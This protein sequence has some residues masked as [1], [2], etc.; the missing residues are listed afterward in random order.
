MERLLYEPQMFNYMPESGTEKYIVGTYYVEDWVEGGADFLD[1]LSGVKRMI[2]EGSTG[3]WQEVKEE[4]PEVRE[5]LAGKLLGYYEV[6][7]PEGIKRAIVQIGFPIDAWEGNVPMMLLSFAGNCFAYS[8]NLRLLDVVIPHE[9]AR[10]F[11]GPKFGIQG[12]RS[13]LNVYGRPLSLHIIKPKMGMTPEQTAA[14]VYE[15]ALGGVDMVKDDEMTS[16]VFNSKF[17]DR[18]AAVMDA[19]KR[20]EKKTGKKVIYFISVTDEIDVL[21]EKARRAV[22]HGANGL[23]LTY[24]AGLSALRVLAEDPE[25]NVPILLHVSHMLALLPRI[26]FVVLSKLCRLCGADLMLSPTIWSSIPVVSLEECLRCYQVLQAPFYHIK[27]TFPM[28]AAGMHPGLLPVLLQEAGQDIIIP[29]GGGMLG[30]PMGYTAGAKA[31]QQAFE[32][33][34]EGVPLEE[35]AERY[36]E[37]KA[38]LDKWGLFKRPSTPWSHLSPKFVPKALKDTATTR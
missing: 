4:T 9:L 21:R 25:I 19:L 11:K 17:D 23:L 20:A 7:A 31:W 22:R 1:H 28:P 18:L 35:A 12:V 24:S 38:A 8:K 29:A 36:P 14:Q 6:P 26:S 13:L 16:D 32:A 27:P 10:K 30:H 3:S 33:E 2:I 5:R 15:T 37:L 34:M